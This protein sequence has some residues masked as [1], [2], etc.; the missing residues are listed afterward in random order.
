[1]NIEPIAY[2]KNDFKE[3]FG[4]PRQSGLTS[5]LSE[6]VLEE[7][8]SDGNALRGLEDFSHIWL[9]WGF[10]EAKEGFSPT[11]RPP[12]LGGNVRKGVFATRSPFRPNRL[13]ISAVKLERVSRGI[14]TVSGADI[15]NGT[16]VYDIKPYIPYADSIPNASNGWALS[17]KSP[18]LNVEIPCALLEIIPERLR[19]PL[20]EILSQ[21]PRPQYQNDER[22]Y[23]MAFAD[24]QISFIVTGVELTV[25]DIK[26]GADL[27]VD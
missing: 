5:V 9:I 20:T 17:D 27:I 21:D 14:I 3:K 15:L 18:L 26:G 23:T 4:I 19:Q 2:I 22:V 11:V 8:Y 6:V 13:A 25:I 24:F 7:K 16:P 10:S 12:R 1:M